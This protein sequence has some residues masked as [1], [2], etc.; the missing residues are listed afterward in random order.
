LSLTSGLHKYWI[1]LSGETSDFPLHARIFHSVCIIS[2]VGLGYNIPFN[3]LVG[4]PAVSIISFIMMIVVVGLYHMSRNLGKT[5]LSVLITNFVGL[6]LFIVNYFLNSGINGPTAL[7]FL[8]FLLITIA[9]NPAAQYKIWIPFN[10]LI[11]IGLY[12]YEYYYPIDVPNTYDTRLTQFVDQAS[13]Y[14]VIAII[15]F[16]CMDYIRR[17]YEMEKQSTIEKSKAIEKQNLHI[18]MQNDEL[19]RLN[20]QKNKLMSIVAHDLRSPLA[21]I[22]NY[23]EVLRDF[24]I[25]ASQKAD[26]EKDLLHA[27][28]ETLSMLSKLLTWSKSQIHGIVVRQEFMSLS[29][30]LESTLELESSTAA[31]KGVELNYR[32]P[33]EHIVYADREM[34]QLVIRNFIGNAIKF[35]ST[36]GS[37]VVRSE[38]GDRECVISISDTGIGISPERRAQLFSLN[39]KSTYGTNGEKGVGL[40]LLLC[41]EYM[42]A[43]GGRI[44]YEDVA[45]GGTCF[46]ISIPVK[47]IIPVLAA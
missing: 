46:Y 36:G 8:L 12:L 39:A 24:D 40:G 1:K 31:L 19:E 6:V 28:K 42:T 45:E 10:V 20:A 7:F 16:F 18:L 3:Y 44:W 17:G 15:A 11:V 21:N 22:Q 27:T 33:S 43:Q 14:I 25:S 13:A 9:I 26:I 2:I 23:L 5:E 29:Q 38:C 41:Q 47:E 4:L 32:F 34:M 30:L 35:T 37:V